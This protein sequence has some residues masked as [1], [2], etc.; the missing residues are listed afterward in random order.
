MNKRDAT[1]ATLTTVG[2]AFSLWLYVSSL[3]LPAFEC[4]GTSE[5]STGF[6]VLLE[7]WIALMLLDVRWLA[8]LTF[9]LLLLFAFMMKPGVHSRG[10]Y[11]V[12]VLPAFTALL[13]WWSWAGPSTGGCGMSDGTA[14]SVKSLGPGGLLWVKA[15][16]VASAVFTVRVVLADAKLLTS[17]STRSRAET[18]APD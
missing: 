8:N 4:Y 1:I 5:S 17:H 6:E 15:L 13:A 12:L 3:R 18:R 10:I 9:P 7:G 11:V 14:N 16:L 2:G